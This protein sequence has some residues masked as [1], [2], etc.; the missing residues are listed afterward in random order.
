MRNA[1]APAPLHPWPR[2]S[3]PCQRI[4]VDFA[5]PFEGKMFLLVVDAHSK[6]PDII[7]MNSTTSTQT[8]T[9]LR[10]LFAAHGLPTQLV[11]DNW[12][13]FNSEEFATFC[14]KN[15]VKHI[16]YSP[17]HTASNGLAERLVQTF[18]KAMKASRGDQR[19]CSHR[20]SSFLLQYRCTPHA[21]TNTPPCEL[22]VGRALRIYLYLL[23]PPTA[24]D[25]VA[26]KQ[27]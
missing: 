11:S 18:K 10:R 12:P 2:P 22:F 8:I 15:G 1:P 20:L 7:E 26:A 25:H 14:K 17:Y 4:Y 16:R 5:G 9:E 3:K 19:Q 13:Q 23:R 21:T 24:S 27:E 6:W